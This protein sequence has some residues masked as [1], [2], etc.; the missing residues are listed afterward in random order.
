M[1]MVMDPSLANYGQYVPVPGYTVVQTT[2]Q[3]SITTHTF[4]RLDPGNYTGNFDQNGK[5]K[6]P[7]KCT[8]VDG[9][10]YDGEWQD[11]LRHGKGNFV[12]REGTTY[13]GNFMDDIRHGTGTLTYKS[14]NKIIG[15]QEIISKT[16]ST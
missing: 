15:I 8:W 4:T 1:Q 11:G 12:S 2:W 3:Q 9:S 10:T 5:R 16:F 13:D 14:G 6:G 7:G